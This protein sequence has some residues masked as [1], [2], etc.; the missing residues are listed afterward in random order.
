VREPIWKSNGRAFAMMHIRWRVMRMWGPF[1]PVGIASRRA[2]M[3]YYDLKGV[4]RNSVV[5]H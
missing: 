4:R 5:R 3:L 1:K 2:F